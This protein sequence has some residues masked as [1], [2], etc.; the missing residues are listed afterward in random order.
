MS[1]SQSENDKGTIALLPILLIVSFLT[2]AFGLWL[3]DSVQKRLFQNAIVAGTLTN[4][5]RVVSKTNA[6][7]LANYTYTLKWK[8]VQETEANVLFKK[9]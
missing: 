6:V 5:Y 3:G 4:D 7:E 9:P 1:Y 2:F 8:S